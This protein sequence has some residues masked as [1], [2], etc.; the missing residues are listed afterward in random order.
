MLRMIAYGSELNLA[1]P[2]RPTD[3]AASWEPEWAAKIRV[4]SVLNAML[5]MEQTMGQAPSERDN[6]SQ[7]GRENEDK[8]GS[9]GAPDGIDQG[10]NKLKGIFGL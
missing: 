3:P 10:I 1:H 9:E 5:G 7:P 2:P 6:G 4:K 8:S